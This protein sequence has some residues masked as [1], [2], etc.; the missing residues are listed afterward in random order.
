[1]LKAS[2]SSLSS[3]KCGDNMSSPFMFGSL[4]SSRSGSKGSMDEYSG[5]LLTPVFK[6]I[7]DQERK[8]SSLA[9]ADYRGS[10]GSQTSEQADEFSLP[11]ACET[12]KV[13]GMS[14]TM[15]GSDVSCYQGLDPDASDPESDVPENYA[16][17]SQLIL[18]EILLPSRSPSKTIR[19]TLSPNPCFPIILL[20]VLRC[21]HC[22]FSI[23]LSSTMNKIITILMA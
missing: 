13:L 8:R 3:E 12:R 5:G 18:T 6:R 15:G 9:P 22:L 23:F 20:Q 10:W 19:R 4:S 11:I 16:S 17:F 1:M 7:H 14:G 2:F 21:C